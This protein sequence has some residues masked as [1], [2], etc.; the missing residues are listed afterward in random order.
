MIEEIVLEMMTV[1][2]AF[3]KTSRELCGKTKQ[4]NNPKKQ[5][6]HKTVHVIRMEQHSGLFRARL[7]EAS[8]SK[9]K[10]LPS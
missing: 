4:N 1:K 9:A 10:C 8:V 7:K 3:E 6:Q 2:E 5:Q